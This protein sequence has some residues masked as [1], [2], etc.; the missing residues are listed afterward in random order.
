MIDDVQSDGTATTQDLLDDLERGRGGGDALYYSTRDR[1][2]T[3]TMHIS[4]TLL[5]FGLTIVYLRDQSG[6]SGFP[7]LPT[8]TWALLGIQLVAASVAVFSAQRAIVMN[9]RYDQTDRWDNN[10][11]FAQVFA[12]IAGTFLVGGSASP[13]W[14]AVG[15]AAT[16]AATL[17]VGRL[18]WLMAAGL[19]AGAAGSAT[20]NDQWSSGLA[21]S[22]AVVIGHTAWLPHPSRHRPA[23]L[24]RVRSKHVGTAPIGRSSP[25]PHTPVGTG[26]RWRP[27]SRR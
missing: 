22:L 3:I 9:Y 24:H 11:S 1:T 10:T 25:R 4:V 23:A 20:Y 17:V 19:V 18:G 8:L 15:V 13:L 21:T 5:C 26:R 6:V 7:T 14:F 12:A 27:I 16:Y 2:T